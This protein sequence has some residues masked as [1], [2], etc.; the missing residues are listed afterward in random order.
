MGHAQQ[1]RD[2]PG[3][4]F[5]LALTSLRVGVQIGFVEQNH[6]IGTAAA[7]Q[8]EVAFNPAQV[9]ILIKAADNQ[10]QIDIGGND[11]FLRALIFALTVTGEVAGEGA[12][13]SEQGNNGSPLL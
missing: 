7:D 11:L 4:G 9:I 2:C 6:R 1:D 10:D 13:A 5:N 8:G 3:N 12:F